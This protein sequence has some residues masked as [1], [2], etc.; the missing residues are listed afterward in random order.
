MICPECGTVFDVETPAATEAELANAHANEMF[1]EA[2]LESAQHA[3]EDDVELAEAEADEVEALADAAVSVAAIEAVA[4]VAQSALETVGST[5]PDDEG[6]DGEDDHG[7]EETAGGAD[8]EEEEGHEGEPTPEE[9]GEARLEEHAMEHEALP[10]QSDDEH[11]PEHVEPITMLG[12]QRERS[13][14]RTVSAW[15]KRRMHR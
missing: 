1:A 6:D 15:Q 5:A 2:Q 10:P 8:E 11:E 7:D 9:I 3:T 13:R 12:T 4:Q 14:T